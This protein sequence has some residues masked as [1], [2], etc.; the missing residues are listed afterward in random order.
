MNS[1][2][3][4]DPARAWVDEFGLTR[5]YSTGAEGYTIPNLEPTVS[6]LPSIL[7]PPELEVY[8]EP[9][10]SQNPRLWPLWY[11]GLTVMTMS[12]GATVVSLFST[13]YTSGI[14]GLQEEF[15]ISK[16][17]A[18]LGITTYLLGMATG[19]IIFAPLSEVVGRR[20]VYIVSM[21]IFLSLILPSALAS[22]IRS[23][24]VSRFFGGFFGSAMMSNSPASVNDIVS[25]KHRALAFGFWSIGPTNGPVYGPII[26]GFIFE[27]LGW[28]WT[29]WIVLIIGGFVL[30]LMASIKETYAPVILRKRA[31]KQRKE[32]QNP[33]WWTRY[34]GGQDLKALLSTSLSRPF[35]MI[36]TEPICMFWDT[37]VAIVYAVLYLCFV[38]Y[39]I[40]FQQERGWSPGIGGLSFIGI[41]VGVLLAIAFEPLF[42]KVINLHRKDPETGAVPPEAMVSIV[43]FGATL[44][45][46]GQLWFAWTCT[47]NVH[48]IAPILAGVPFGAGNACVFIY[49]NNYMA[50]SY[51]IY[52]ASALAGNMVLRSIMGACLP[53]AGPSM[54]GTLGLNWASTLLGIVEAVCILIPIGFYFYG[55]K[56]RNA[57]PLIKEMERHQV[58]R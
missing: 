29:N 11:K 35:V 16:I 26:G 30:M 58:S 48:W 9:Q 54:Y 4:R 24:L 33:K 14:P 12:L 6:K 28:R 23:I 13:L 21:T 53:L 51:G 3:H 56:I 18:L 52:A 5:S 25:D 8:W 39:P 2:E 40:A 47:P 38:A 37:Y 34:D 50:R 41:G 27:Y 22:N 15:H 10:D 32:T 49:A 7:N 19:S 42:R 45:A 36:I 43:C 1:L 57:S 17:V 44:L 31:E 46:I 20:P 55:H